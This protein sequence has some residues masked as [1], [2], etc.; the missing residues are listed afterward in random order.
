MISL[1]A[2]SENLRAGRKSAMG[3]QAICPLQATIS[4][5]FASKGQFIPRL[6]AP[7]GPGRARPGWNAEPRESSSMV[8]MPLFI[9][10][11]RLRLSPRLAS[12][13]ALGCAVAMAASL[14]ANPLVAPPREPSQSEVEAADLLNFGKFMRHSGDSVHNGTFDICI[15][16]RDTIGP[17]IDDLASK[18]S[19]DHLSVRVP[20]I[21]DVTNAKSCEIIFFSVSEDERIREDL[22]LLA[23]NDALTVSDTS[24]FIQRGGMI[25]FVMVADHVRFSVNLTALNRSHLTLSSELLKVAVSV[26][27]RT[28]SEVRHDGLE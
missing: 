23:G 16:G 7:V 26:T 2:R 9:A 4:M 12:F 11:R 1:D 15:L 6:T 28:T 21:A 22:A 19:I 18:E 25:Q 27:G 24:D 17:T 20:R 14:P 13:A 8:R 10:S 3:I 5:F